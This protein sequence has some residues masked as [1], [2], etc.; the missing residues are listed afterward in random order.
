MKMKYKM[1][2]RIVHIL[3]DINVLYLCRCS[4]W[5]FQLPSIKTIVDYVHTILI[6]SCNSSCINFKYIVLTETWLI[7]KFFSNALLLVK[8]KFKSYIFNY[9]FSAWFENWRRVFSRV[10]GKSKLLSNLQSNF[11][12]VIQMMS[13]II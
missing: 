5:F 9:L 1:K 6:F 10:F 4:I 3:S 13:H 12:N 8:F 11:N 2:T 7:G